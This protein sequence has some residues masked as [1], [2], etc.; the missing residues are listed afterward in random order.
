MNYGTSIQWYATLKKN[1]TDLKWGS[2]YIDKCEN[3]FAE[4]MYNITPFVFLSVWVLIYMVKR[5]LINR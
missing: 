3:Q 2:R 4:S 5:W 1:H